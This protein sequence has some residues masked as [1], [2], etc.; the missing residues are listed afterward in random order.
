LIIT[1]R[2]IQGNIGANQNLLAVLRTKRHAAVAVAEHRA[3]HLGGV[4]F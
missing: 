4:V 1:A 2:F 3:A